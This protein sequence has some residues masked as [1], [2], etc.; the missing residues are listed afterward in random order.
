MAETAVTTPQRRLGARGKL[1]P[2]TVEP[3]LRERLLDVLLAPDEPRKLT[4]EEFLEW[5][6]G[7]MHAEW[8]DG[9]VVMASPASDEHQDVGDFLTT[10]LRIFVRHHA[11]GWVRSAPFQ[12]KTGPT[13]PAASPISRSCRRPTSAA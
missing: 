1:L 6:D 13:S 10:L 3:R 8:V 12:M 9:D 5:A 4:Y 11:L 7:G 2:Q